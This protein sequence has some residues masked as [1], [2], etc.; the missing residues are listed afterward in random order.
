MHQFHIPN[1]SLLKWVMVI[2]FAFDHELDRQ[3][4]LVA[5]RTQI[6]P[7][8]PEFMYEKVSLQIHLPWI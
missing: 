5:E 2:P 4:F 6:L 8:G 7:C 1:A 3:S